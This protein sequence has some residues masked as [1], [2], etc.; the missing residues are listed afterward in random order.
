MP[1]PTSVALS[2]VRASFDN[3]A[4]VVALVENFEPPTSATGLA[5]AADIE[6]ADRRS[7]SWASTDRG[8]LTA[9]SA[10]HK[11]AICQMF[12]ETF[13]PYR[14]AVIE[15]PRLTA[16]ALKRL[17]ELPIWDIAVET[18]GKARVSFAAYAASLD[19]AEMRSTILLNAWEENRHKQV[20]SRL[21]E[22]YGIELEQEKHYR[23]PRNLLRGFLITGYSE[24]IDSFF[25][26]GLFELAR[27]SGFFPQALVETFE[28]VIQEECRHI[29]LFA[30]WLSWRRAQL[31]FSARV[32]FELQV[33]GAWLQIAWLRIASARTV[34]KKARGKRLNSNFT[35]KGAQAVTAFK[36]DFCELLEIC[37]LENDRRF[38]GYDRRLARPET[39]PTFARLVLAAS[40]LWR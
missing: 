20:L 39:I 23:L 9:G 25:A 13:N 35:V 31:S 24:C 33:A 29:L 11:R 18:E 37:L 34:G 3:V 19:D 12:R 28:P 30:N 16:E 14:P 36:L 7:K 27:Q 8:N 10:A 40:R 5:T 38:S 4:D 2:S 26:F 15:W 17:Q 22:T 6:S 1:D 32:G 21:V